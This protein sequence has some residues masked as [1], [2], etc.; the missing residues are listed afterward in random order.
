MKDIE[1]ILVNDFSIDN[2]LQFIENLQKEDSRIKII[3]NQKNMCI[4]YSWCIGALS[5]KGRCL[6][7]LDNGDIEY[8]VFVP[9]I[10]LTKK[11]ILIL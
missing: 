8:D 10:I 6:F 1:I 9:F 7:P 5:A 11:M 4:L 3:K 2:A